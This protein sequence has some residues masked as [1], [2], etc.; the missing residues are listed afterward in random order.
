MGLPVPSAKFGWKSP[1][2]SFE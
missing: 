2:D 1:M